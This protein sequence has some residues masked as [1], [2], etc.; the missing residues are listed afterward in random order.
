MKTTLIVTEKP[1]AALHVSEALS[2]E[3]KPR[4]I[5]VSGVP[6]FEVLEKDERILICSALGHLYAVASN[7]NEA[8]SHYPVWDFSWKP[9]HM[10]E[11]G[12]TR[13]ERWIQSISKMSKEADRFINACDYDLEG[14][15]IG[16]TILKYACNGADQ[17]AQRMKFSTL[18]PKELRDAYSR[19]SPK[20]DFELA[21]AGMCR[22]EV[23]WLF[24]IN[25]SRALTQ[26]ALKASHRYS[27]ISTGRVQGPTMR[28]VVD[29]EREIQCH[30]PLPYWVLRSFVDVNGKTV[31]VEYEIEHLNNKMTAQRV[32]KE[33]AGKIGILEKVESKTYDLPPPTPF[34][35]SDLQAEAYRN[36]ILHPRV[37]LGIAERLYLDQI[38]S[39]PR[40]SSQKLPPTIG[41]REILNELSKLGPYH[42]AATKIL[43]SSRLVPKEGRREDP[44]HPAIYPTGTRTKRTLDYRE[45]KLFDLITRRFLAAF[46]ET[47]TKQGNKAIIKVGQHHFFIRGSRIIF[48]GW[49]QYYEQY[50]KFTETNLPSIKE[51]Q[52]IPIRE[53]CIEQKFTQPPLRFNPSSLLRS[54]EDAEIG[55]KA[56]RAEIIDTLHQRT[57][58]KEEGQSM[59]ATPLAFRVSDILTKYC[60][61]VMDVS[62]TH[63]LEAMMEEIEQG[64]NSRERVVH[65]TIQY[66]KPVIENLKSKETEIGTELTTTIREMWMDKITLS[67]LC[68]KC[69]QT[70]I[71]I[72]GKNGKRFIGHKVIAD[73][74]FSLPLPPIHMAE[75][76]LLRKLCPD[77]GFQMVQVKWKG[78]GSRPI[79]S[80]PN[81][82]ASKT[83]HAKNEVAV[84]FQRTHKH[85]VS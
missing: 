53:I 35:L 21:Y 23:D 48:R 61:K 7:G 24:G 5:N 51:G 63:E 30:V 33:C 19:L 31:E 46:G 64:R 47:A 11:H 39:Y 9:K 71:R 54:M 12:Q 18:T 60:P 62:F 40:T 43:E 13:Q 74:T 81:C 68:P 29:R 84:T 3:N 65:A 8:K 73:C 77:C 44:A 17:K 82:Y 1:D 70:L 10:I 75:L 49:I 57:Y 37:T 27:T 45:K 52:Q 26:S 59:A 56:T 50:A 25:L 22:H 76:D 79:I 15:L 67:V 4:K 32:R 14:S 38:I 34:A 83:K 20:L 80:C 41:Y 28:F 36:F 78:R 66:L 2:G 72:A 58:V 42:D 69:G 6:F 85:S 16:Y 55:T